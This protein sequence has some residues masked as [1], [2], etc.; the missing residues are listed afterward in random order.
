MGTQRS[1]SGDVKDIFISSGVNERFEPFCTVSINGGDLL[2]QLTPKEV[3]RL[4]LQWLE[5]AEAA[6]GDS[7]VFRVAAQFG[8]E[9]EH[10][11]A[12]VMEMRKLRD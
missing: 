12:F 11:A 6:E 3:R 5:A 8:L 2:G 10:A 7:L 4:A 1:T 9:R